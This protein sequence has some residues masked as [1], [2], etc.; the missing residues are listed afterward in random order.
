MTV[1]ALAVL[2]SMATPV[3]ADLTNGNFEAGETGWTVS[4]PSKIE[5]GFAYL[6]EG[7]TYSGGFNSTSIEQSS[8]DLE[9]DERVLSFEFWLE[10]QG[11]GGPES[12]TFEVL[13]NDSL[14]FS[15][16]ADDAPLHQTRL[17]DVSSLLF[18]HDNTLLFRLVGE[19]DGLNTTVTL[20]KVHFLPAVPLPGAAVLGSMGLALAGWLCRRGMC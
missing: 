16:S 14:V 10:K 4:S 6:V 17:E 5:D 13:F 1:A 11:T 9:P 20:D 19:D 3:P 15:A 7:A 2:L 18:V 8:F 12:D